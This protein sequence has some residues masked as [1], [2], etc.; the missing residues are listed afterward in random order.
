M[1]SGY[2]IRNDVIIMAMLFYVNSEQQILTKIIR[3]R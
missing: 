1:A 3:L 2:A